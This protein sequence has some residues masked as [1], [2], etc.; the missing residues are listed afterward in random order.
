MR[1]LAAFCAAIAAVLVLTNGGL[2]AVAGGNPGKSTPP[3]Q[4]KKADDAGGQSSPPGQEHIPPGQQ[5]KADEGSSSGQPD[6]NVAE[7][8]VTTTVEQKEQ[9]GQ[10]E[11]HGRGAVANE[12]SAASPEAKHTSVPRAADKPR[13]NGKEAGTQSRPDKNSSAHGNSAVAHTHVI[14][15][16]RTGS[17]SNPYVVINISMSAWVHGH[18]THPDLDGRSDILLKV[19]AAPGEKLPK[20]SCGP[21]GHGGG[22][23]TPNDPPGTPGDPPTKV[24]DP[25]PGGIPTAP[26]GSPATG[27]TAVPA[28]T[29][30]VKGGHRGNDSGVASQL[31]ETGVLGKLPFTGV[32]LWI[33]ALLGLVLLATGLTLLAVGN[34]EVTF[35]EERAEDI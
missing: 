9:K 3:G 16:H 26:T 2:A 25:T 33:A 20:S 19:G 8:V 18:S 30:G 32:P 21:P 5:K 14:I 12:R 28:T 1:G 23:G 7:P 4:E 31:G 10:K 27:P 15:C 13:P 24:H 29:K 11:D 34:W 17:Q 6:T 22:G 35:T